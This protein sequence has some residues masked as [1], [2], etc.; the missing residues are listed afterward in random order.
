MLAKPRK[1]FELHILN[2]IIYQ[3]SEIT[4]QILRNVSA[5]STFLKRL[6]HG[7]PVFLNT[8]VFLDR[9]HQNNKL[10]FRSY[11][12]RRQTQGPSVELITEKNIHKVKF[13]I[14]A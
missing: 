8:V 10:S 3:I 6:D 7:V 14:D 1:S 13:L 4:Q 5:K 12:Q 11:E 2:T 9:S